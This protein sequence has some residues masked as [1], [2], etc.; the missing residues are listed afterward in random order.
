MVV[1]LLVPL[2]DQAEPTLCGFPF[3]FWFQFAMILGAAALTWSPTISAKA[4]DRT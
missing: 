3:F 4:A 2:Y 1:P